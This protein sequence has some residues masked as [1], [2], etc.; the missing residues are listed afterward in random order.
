MSCTI[1]GNE[2]SS[3]GGMSSCAATNCTIRGNTAGASGGGIWYPEADSCIILENHAE[4]S[5]GTYSSTLRY[6]TVVNN[7]TPM[8][9]ESP[10]PTKSPS[11]LSA[12]FRICAWAPW[13]GR[14]R[15]ANLISTCS[16]RKPTTSLPISGVMSARRSSGKSRREPAGS[17][18]AFP[19][20]GKIVRA[21][22]SAVRPCH[23]DVEGGE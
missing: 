5:A 6:C 2:G 14:W 21:A 19:R 20:V 13:S 11:F 8:A 10:M 9:T 22:E 16:C 1:T 17:F 18:S 23:I 7:T 3:G 12:P 4:N 15:A